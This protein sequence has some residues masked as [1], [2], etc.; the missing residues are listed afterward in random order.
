MFS[1][2]LSVVTIAITAT[3]AFTHWHRNHKLWWQEMGFARIAVLPDF[4]AGVV[5]GA[6][7]MAGI[8]GVHLV[9]GWLQFTNEPPTMDWLT[10]IPVLLIAAL[11]EEVLYRGLV[12]NGLVILTRQT[13]IAV[14]LSAILFGIAHATNPGATALSVVSNA[15][16][17]VMYSIAFLRTRRLWLPLGVHFAWNYF[18]GPIFGFLVSGFIFG[19]LLQHTVVGNPIFTGGSYGPEGGLVAIAFRFVV[20]ALIVAWTRR[21][22]K[23]VSTSG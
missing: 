23:R 6:L 1:T 21:G 16:G 8:Y 20:I 14:V 15:L 9:M 5:I 10:T 2:L 11:V 13:W 17:G 19:G 18:Q 12:L 4:T 3:I 7:V 22:G